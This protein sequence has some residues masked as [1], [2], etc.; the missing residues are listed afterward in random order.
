MKAIFEREGANYVWYDNAINANIVRERFW[1]QKKLFGIV[2][3]KKRWRQSS[4]I[5]EE[6]ATKKTGF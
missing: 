5:W 4:N 3:Y 1:L 2:I 6:K